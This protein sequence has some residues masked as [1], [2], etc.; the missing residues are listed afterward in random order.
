[1][2]VRDWTVVHTTNAELFAYMADLRPPRRGC[3]P[4]A[5]CFVPLGPLPQSFCADAAAPPP[6][7]ARASLQSSDELAT[8]FYTHRRCCRACDAT[9]VPPATVSLRKDLTRCL[10]RTDYAPTDPNDYARV[11]TQ[12]NSTFSR[13]LCCLAK[14]PS[15]HRVLDVAFGLG[16]TART[17][18]VCLRQSGKLHWHI[19]GF[20]TDERV[21]TAAFKRL[22][23]AGV[24]SN[25]TTSRRGI[26]IVNERVSAAGL[27][28]LCA[29]NA[30][31]LAIVDPTDA[32]QDEFFEVERTCAP[33]LYL[34]NNVNLPGHVG[35][36]VEYLLRLGGW[37]EV[38]SGSLTDVQ[39]ASNA[40]KLHGSAAYAQLYRLRGWALL[41][42]D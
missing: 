21:A 16:G 23:R 37:T 34:M 38:M 39:A 12:P 9:D 22:R 10:A 28:R 27:K 25:S 8:A 17:A 11:T 7:S 1:M 33:R 31:D 3:F 20:E 36:A 41:Q 2:N 40:E 18:G 4:S 24:G 26:S 35:W 6:S 5:L 19:G 32:F 13:V 42:R 29:P 30:P 15:V 14:Q